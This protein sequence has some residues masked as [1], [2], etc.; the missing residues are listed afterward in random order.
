MTWIESRADACHA[1]ML[2][3]NGCSES[4]IWSRIESLSANR[5]CGVHVALPGRARHEPS[6]TANRLAAIAQRQ[7]VLRSQQISG[8]DQRI[9]RSGQMLGRTRPSCLAGSVAAPQAPRKLPGQLRARR[10]CP[11]CTSACSAECRGTRAVAGHVPAALL[12]RPQDEVALE[13][14]GR[15]LEQAVAGVGPAAR[16]GRS[17]TRAAGPLRR[18]SPCR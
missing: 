4:R 12:E 7:R 11:S 1:R 6:R 13:G 8:R 15:I 14:V 9:G 3:C 17:G 5:D 18:C 10:A 16:A 2:R